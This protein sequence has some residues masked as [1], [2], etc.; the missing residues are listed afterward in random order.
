MF[1]VTVRF[2]ISSDNIQFFVPL[3]HA[4]AQASVRD[5]VGCQ[6]FDVLIDPAQPNVVFLYEIYDDAAAFQAHLTTP[7]FKSFDEQ[8]SG[9]V[10]SKQI[11]TFAQV[12]R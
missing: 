10:A 2:E 5:E 6:Q 7:H 4:N 8:T 1:A 3:V 12:L 11:D 9:M